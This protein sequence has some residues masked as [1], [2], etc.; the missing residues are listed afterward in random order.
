MT[1][2]HYIEFAK[3]IKSS[4]RLNHSKDKFIKD[5][6]RYFELQNTR[7]DKDRFLEASDLK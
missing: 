3:L 2:K 5:L 1:K 7:F 6:I 4:N